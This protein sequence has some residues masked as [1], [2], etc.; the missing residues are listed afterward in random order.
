M[1]AWWPDGCGAAGRGDQYCQNDPHARA[2][3]RMKEQRTPKEG[4]LHSRVRIVFDSERKD[5]VC[6]TFCLAAHLFVTI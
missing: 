2:A 5:F 6:I 3:I 4:V 1:V